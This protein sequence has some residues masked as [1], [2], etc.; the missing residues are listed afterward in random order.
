MRILYNSRKEEYKTPF[1]TLVPEEVCVLHL[2]IPRDVQ[3]SIVELIVEDAQGERAASFAFAWDGEA[4]GY[5]SFKCDF[6]LRERGLYFYWFRIHGNNGPFRLFR[7]GDGTNMEEGDKWQLSVVPEERKA[8]EACMGAVI[9]QIFPDRFCRL[10][11][12][13]TTD[14]LRP[15]TLRED[16]GGQP[17]YL[18]DENGEVL[19]NDFFGGNFR[20]IT[21]R[22]DYLRSL[23]V[24]ILYLNPICM[25]FSNHR[26]DT[27]D[28]RRPDP[29]LGTEDD[30]RALCREAH[31]RGMRVIV[32]GVY[33]HTGS[34]SVYFDRE[35]RFGNGACSGESS[36]YYKWYTFRSFPDDYD[37]WWN[38]P[39]LPN[40]NELEPSYVDFIIENEDSVIAYWLGLGADGFRLD[41]V[42][43]LPDEFVLRFHRRLR[44]LKPDALLIGEVWEDASNKT[45]YDV[46]RRYF[47][48]RELSSTMNYPWQ[49]AIIAFCK[50]YDGG[51]AL[52]EV[53]M[54]IAE[55]YPPDVL[56]C[57]MN[58]LGSHD[59]MRILTELAG[60]F[61]GDRAYQAGVV[62]SPEQRALGGKRLRMASFLQYTLPGSP[63]IYYG[64]EAGMEGCKDPF[65]RGC[66][67]WGNEDAALQAHYRRLG[68]LKRAEPALRCGSVEVL[69]AGDG[70]FVFARR[71]HRETLMCY[72]NR[73]ELAMPLSDGK[74][75]YDD[76]VETV[77]GKPVLRPG[78]CA[79]VRV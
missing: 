61:D 77:E 6:S 8:P 50:G 78:G 38:F 31:R 46:H 7:Q 33:S 53:V 68:A 43:E 66:F 54:T 55:N 40:V 2:R 20:G 75:C 58:L 27:C 79:C 18:P 39:T 12:C 32:D 48:D 69:E 57:M 1:G 51:E 28:Y 5:D 47:V 76:G 25:A 34:R 67:P 17:R 30:F 73:S 74:L 10:G 23:G 41:V 52:G 4:D 49:K 9:Y 24:T 21:S 63:S 37:C 19:C 35:G 3:A 22:L 64:D 62:L 16:W 15:F 14:K 45:A 11:D 71:L 56:H 13:D 44:A 26:Y 29:L 72:V 36:P 60:D 65:C 70:R 59:T 42:D